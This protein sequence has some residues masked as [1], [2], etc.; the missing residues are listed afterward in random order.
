MK[1]FKIYSDKYELMDTFPDA[2]DAYAFRG[3]LVDE[4]PKGRKVGYVIMEDDSV[5]ECYEKFNPL[6]VVVPVSVVVIASAAVTAYFLFG[7]PKDVNGFGGLLVKQGDDR[8]VVSYNGFMAIEEGNLSVCFQ[9][10]DEPASIGIVADGITVESIS[11]EPG[12]YV[13]SVPAT[14]TTESGLVN[15]KLVITTETSEV[16]NDIV[17]E[18]PENN[19]PNCPE[20]G[21]EGY[22]KG[23]QVYGSEV[24]S[25]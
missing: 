11:I 6:L 4:R 10:G 25:E 22:W 13:A 23:E 3:R 7:Q 20:S 9:N 14:F 1:R 19:T 16:E 24:G 21:L 12:E 17:I 8:N 5:I 18:I 15:A 2:P